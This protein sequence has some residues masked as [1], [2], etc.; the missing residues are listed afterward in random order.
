MS[1]TEFNAGQA[2][3]W[4]MAV[5]NRRAM[6]ERRKYTRWA[7][8]QLLLNQPNDYGQEYGDFVPSHD[9]HQTF[10]TCELKLLFESL[11]DEQAVILHGLFLLGKTERELAE[12]LNITQQ[13]VSRL[14]HR[15][16]RVLKKELN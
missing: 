14:K 3:C 15:A 8:E 7:N 4:C 12:D 1:Q 10:N 5:I 11:P 16:L 2:I 9:A 6:K 13:K